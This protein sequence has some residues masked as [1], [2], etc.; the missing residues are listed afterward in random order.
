MSSPPRARRLALATGLTYNILEWGAE[1]DQTI[2]LVHGFLDLA[3]GWD[4]V[5]ELLARRYHVIAPDLRGHGD[6][7][8]IGPGGY[9]H[10]FDYLPDLDE[11]VARLA[12]GKVV[13]VGHS[14]GGSV[15]AYWAGTRPEQVRALVLLEGIGP[16]E[17]TTPVPDRAAR[18][19]DAWRTAR[20]SAK[21]MPSIEDAAARLRKHDHLLDATRALRL[22]TRG[23]REV[24]GGHAWKHDPL[25]LTQ[26]PYPYRVDTAAQFWQ[27][28]TAPVLYLEGAL[29]RFRLADADTERRLAAFPRCTR[30]VIADAAHMMMRHQPAAVAAAIESVITG[31]GSS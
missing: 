24:P 27:R 9:Y 17:A 28:V 1:H 31:T 26:G 4:E 19:I 25:H 8:W 16:P 7:D 10:F 6:S 21:V 15:A 14:M 3:W 18:W 23:T 29:S 22:A 11:V 30:T 5:P 20:A 2:V 13:M 12:R